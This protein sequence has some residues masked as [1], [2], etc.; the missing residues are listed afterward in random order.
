MLLKY[1]KFVWHISI[2]VSISASV[3]Q[4]TAFVVIL[5]IFN[6]QL[7]LSPRFPKDGLTVFSEINCE[8]FFNRSLRSA[9]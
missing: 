3:S 1:M 4:K 5:Y 6:L 2:S 8:V 9:D 7:S